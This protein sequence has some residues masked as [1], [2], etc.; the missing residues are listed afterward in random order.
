VF[1]TGSLSAGTLIG[2]GVVLVALGAGSLLAARAGLDALPVPIVVGLAISAAGS[3]HTVRPDPVVT[4]SAAELAVV[5]L[6]FCAGFDAGRR[7]RRSAAATAPR[8]LLA[9]DA[10]LNFVPGAAFGLLAGFGPTGAVLLGG[11]G[12]AS[13]WAGVAGFLDREGRYG[14]RE[15]PAVLAV[16][17]IEHAAAAVYLPLAAALLAPGDGAARVTAVLGSAGALAVAAWLVLGPAPW[18]R[19]DRIDGPAPG[20]GRLLVLTGAAVGA[21]G[22]AAA[23]GLATTGVA[24]L[25]GVVLASGERDGHR[26]GGSDGTRRQLAG[27]RALALTAAGLTLGLL[28]PP[29]RLPGAV[30][31]GLVLAGLGVAGK[32]LTGWWAAGRLRSP[33]P[34]VGRPGRLRAGVAL[35]PRGELAVAIGILAALSSPR[36]GPGTALAALAAAEVVLTGF[37][38]SAVGNPGAGSGYGWMVGTRADER[39]R[40]PR[41]D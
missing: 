2:L 37:V 5:V 28:V 32:M 20:A 36:H 23:L 7:D 27:L 1:A 6:L 21:A 3:L 18:R 10:T 22:V 26:S 30:G 34:V 13:S 15:T 14:N 25:V 16:L 39:H 29:A 12:W 33:G 19:V 4:R 11:V 31:G 41:A 17:V 24:Y 38:P 35:V 9:V 40:S 8:P